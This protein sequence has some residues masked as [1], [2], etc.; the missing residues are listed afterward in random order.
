MM[1]RV[2]WLLFVVLAVSVH[3]M[4]EVIRL[5]EEPNGPLPAASGPDTTVLADQHKRA[6][7]H[8]AQAKAALDQAVAASKP[9][10]AKRLK[11]ATDLVTAKTNRAVAKVE[12]SLAKVKQHQEVR[13]QEIE[14]LSADAGVETEAMRNAIDYAGPADIEEARARAQHEA[15]QAA[16]ALSTLNK[17]MLDDDTSADNQQASVLSDEL[18]EA[19]SSEKSAAAKEEKIEKASQLAVKVDR[20]KLALAE[21][22]AV[23]LKEEHEKAVAEKQA[24]KEESAKAAKAATEVQESLTDPADELKKAELRAQQVNAEL[25]HQTDSLNKLKDEKHDASA[26][27]LA[28]KNTEH[29]LLQSEK[30]QENQIRSAERIID[31]AKAKEQKAIRDDALAE[32]KAKQAAKLEQ[33]KEDNAAKQAAVI[34]RGQTRVAQMKQKLQEAKMV[35]VEAGLEASNSKQSISATTEANLPQAKAEGL[36]SA[37]V[38]KAE[39]ELADETLKLKKSQLQK[40]QE[41]RKNQVLEKK[42]AADAKA[43]KDA[44]KK[45]LKEKAK[46]AQSQQAVEAAEAESAS[47]AAKAQEFED[48][49][50]DAESKAAQAKRQAQVEAAFEKT[51]VLRVNKDKAS[52]QTAKR[53]VT[54]DLSHRK[55]NELKLQLLHTALVHARKQ[56]TAAREAA[57]ALYMS[58]VESPDKEKVIATLAEAKF[59]VHKTER[60]IRKAQAKKASAGAKHVKLKM[61]AA[62]MGAQLAKDEEELSQ[63]KVKKDAEVTALKDA[64]AAASKA[65]NAGSSTINEASQMEQ[66]LQ[67]EK[68]KFAQEEGNLAQA[69]DAK[70]HAKAA[71]SAKKTEVSEAD[72]EIEK[73]QDKIDKLK[74]VAQQDKL[75]LASATSKQQALTAVSKREADAEAALQVEMAALKRATKREEAMQSAFQTAQGKAKSAKAE[76][77]TDASYVKRA[78]AAQ[79]KLKAKESSEKQAYKHATERVQGAEKQ[80][81]AVRKQ[82][83]EMHAAES[84][85]IGE[86]QSALSAEVSAKAKMSQAEAAAR[87]AKNK[88]RAAARAAKTAGPTADHIE[89]KQKKA[90]S[91]VLA[92]K[93]H[94]KWT[95]KV[96]DAETQLAKEQ[97]NVAV[98]AAEAARNKT[99]VQKNSVS[100]D[101]SLR[102]KADADVQVA[103]KLAEATSENMKQ[104]SNGDS[105]LVKIAKNAHAAKI[106]KHKA[107]AQQKAAQFK[108]A[109]AATAS[110]QRSFDAADAESEMALRTASDAAANYGQADTAERVALEKL[111]TML[112]TDEAEAAEEAAAQTRTALATSTKD[113]E[114]SG[115]EES[116]W[117]EQNAKELEQAEVN[118]APKREASASATLGEAQA[119][120]HRRTSQLGK[121]LQRAQLS[122]DADEEEDAIDAANGIE[123]NM[124]NDQGGVMLKLEK[125]LNDAINHN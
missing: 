42:E 22:Q 4:E 55:N 61:Q 92:D 82:V 45:F 79:S 87:A 70:N 97:L 25:A 58:N 103:N 51:K 39:Q 44:D 14:E 112:P 17:E 41:M 8:A 107:L 104:Y 20:E 34:Q 31:K 88:A 117:A 81:D 106:S 52:E 10:E 68:Q 125:T 71:V 29:N 65:K 13:Q 124:P 28:L 108:E 120:K 15:A 2:L 109:A 60:M 37:A 89:I 83:K 49:I 69:R 16:Q 38:A 21:D 12:A 66:K 121:M 11:A 101:G 75:A 53:A 78:Y 122:L 123:V 96:A 35:A 119:V 30:M 56:E 77:A 67:Q 5:S 3:S 59:N 27:V 54:D 24:T 50:K 84:K 105:G 80:L 91:D 116:L 100:D 26:H 19:E 43:S 48:E 102:A 98:R 64:E 110:S 57:E 23:Q 18:T 9:A 74:M 72:Q 99:L 6:Q 115:E 7:A 32:T 113:M 85:L 36:L 1:E 111:K 62:E 40:Q 33:V 73:T 46:A 95:K 94:L 118:S 76:V 93:E 86:G 114:G 63:I 47:A 90:Q